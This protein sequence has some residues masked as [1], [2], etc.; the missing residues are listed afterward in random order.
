MT[1]C[2]EAA[3][4]PTSFRLCPFGVSQPFLAQSTPAH[5]PHLQKHSL[6]IILSGLQAL[7]I[8]KMCFLSPAL[9]R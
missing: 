1:F 6:C 9:I 4:G 8:S 2:S 7:H 5:P 3:L